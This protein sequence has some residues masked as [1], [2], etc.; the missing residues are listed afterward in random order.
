MAI[1][2][3]WGAIHAPEGDEIGPGIDDSHVKR[4]AV[5]LGLSSGGSDRG[6]SARERNRRAIRNVERHL[7]GD[8]VERIGLL[9][10]CRAGKAETSSQNR[11]AQRERHGR[12]SRMPRKEILRRSAPLG[13]EAPRCSATL[14]EI[15]K[16]T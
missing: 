15:T 3:I 5:F 13:K 7:V 4:P 2:P 6:L 10:A 14:Y 16:P 12:S 1:E 11:N 9:R 8:D